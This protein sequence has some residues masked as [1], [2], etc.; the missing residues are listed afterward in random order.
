MS[1][2]KRSRSLNRVF[3]TGNQD[4]KKGVPQGKTQLN[5][6]LKHLD[7]ELHKKSHLSI[8]QGVSPSRYLPMLK[9]YNTALR[10]N[11]EDKEIECPECHEKITVKLPSAA[12][13]RNSVQTL[14][15][16]MDRMFPKLQS[17]DHTVSY[18][19]KLVELSTSV[20]SVVV[21]YV[22]FEQREQCVA[23]MKA[24]IASAGSDHE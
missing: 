12:L 24:A 4:L 5:W 1:Q 2:D 14:V 21:K 23:E 10:D 11:H 13:E 8:P 17:V 7:N 6:M 22:S 16:L 9:A 20:I 15:A 18:S 19:E 3:G